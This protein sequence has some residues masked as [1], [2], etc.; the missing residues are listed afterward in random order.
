MKS[1]STAEAASR[2]GRGPQDTDYSEESFFG[3]HAF[4]L[5]ANDPYTAL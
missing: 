5:G 4:F 1:A 3:R 2:A